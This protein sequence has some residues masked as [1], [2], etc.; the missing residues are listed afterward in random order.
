M[1]RELF[2]ITLGYFLLFAISSYGLGSLILR[3]VKIEVSQIGIRILI[4]LGLI[5][6]VG[7]VLALFGKFEKANLLIILSIILIVG[8]RQIIELFKY[9]Y[10]KI[11]IGLKLI[12]SDVFT[13]LVLGFAL[14]VAGT[15]YLAALAPPH[16]TDELHYHFPQARAVAETG[17]VSW[18]WDGHYFY[19]NIPKLGEMIFAEG[20]L[21]S[22]YSLAH[23]LNYLVM[24]GFLILVFG[25]IKKR[26]GYRA[27]V[28][29]V[30]LL[31][32]FED[33][34]WNATVGFVDSMTTAMEVGS[35]LLV[36]DWVSRRKDKLL[37]AAG[38]ILGL[39]LSIKYSPLPTALYLTV[40]ILVT[41]WRKILPFVVP[42]FLV[43]GYWYIKN[44][45]LFGNP[46]YPMYFGHR[47]VSEESYQ[48]LMNAI[49]QWEPKTWATFMKKLGRWWT[50]SGSTTYLSI[51]LA[52]LVIFINRKDKFILTLTGFYIMF[53]PYWFL[54][55][56]HQ[57]RFLL[58]GLVIASILTGILVAKIPTKV[59]AI[60]LLIIILV[61]LRVRPYEARN[62]LQHYLWIK[63][64]AVERQYAL[65]NLTER[66]YL[67]REFG[68]QYDVVK[69]LE[70]NQL[71][72]K[73]IDNWSQYYAP[74]VRYFARNNEFVQMYEV[75]DIK[76]LGFNYYFVRETTKSKLFRDL[77][78]NRQYSI[79]Y[80]PIF[81]RVEDE[82]R[83]SWNEIV[84]ID[85]CVLYE[86]N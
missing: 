84:T 81:L 79:K 33:F 27:A 31:L 80:G 16:A 22:D 21:I 34:T 83:G 3:R 62:L 29:S 39:S 19:G 48:G 8:Y 64:Q 41:N 28:F 1:S 7:L 43:G 40:I 20:L 5:G 42:A 61:S 75:D 44:W 30:A 12:K 10:Q 18:S 58:T 38:L 15:L 25:L 2:L 36:A 46:F 13:S 26:Y 53:I 82:L 71:D 63:L 60:G 70:D 14:L 45:I 78:E 51:W 11:G 54:F 65:G 23:A 17:K 56:T 55:A 67:S 47:G 6:N 37:T 86:L 35:L 72:G 76:S 59:V 49:W 77:G 52:P 69:Y 50:Y 73:V 57:T 9:W 74:S 66:E 4:G 85:D 24:I 68:C 32:L